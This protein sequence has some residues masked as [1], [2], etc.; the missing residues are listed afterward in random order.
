MDVP[1]KCQL[2]CRTN[3][4]STSQS[5]R[6][7]PWFQLLVSGPLQPPSGLAPQR[8]NHQVWPQMGS[9]KEG[10]FLVEE[11]VRWNSSLAAMWGKGSQHAEKGG[12]KSCWGYLHS[13]GSDN[14]YFLFFAC[15]AFPWNLGAQASW[16]WFL[17]VCL[18]AFGR[19][20]YCS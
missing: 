13:C 14:L 18:L 20:V 16:S 1:Q 4:L 15:W 5:P 9:H 17:W 12:R 3:D 10:W 7:L 11:R 19:R 8:I 6:I 2:S